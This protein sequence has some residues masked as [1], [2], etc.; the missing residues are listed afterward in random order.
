VRAIELVN[1]R[2]DG[3]IDRGARESERA[4]GKGNRADERRPGESR[5]LA[6]LTNFA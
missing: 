1:P 5:R 6:R 2:R 3:G 4:D